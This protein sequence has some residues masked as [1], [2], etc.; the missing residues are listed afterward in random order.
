[1]NAADIRAWLASS[2]D[3]AQGVALYAQAGTS[4]AFK[5][6]F[7]LGATPYSQDVL[8]RELRGLVVEQPALALPAPAPEPVL[9]PTPPPAAED[10][11]PATESPPPASAVVEAL[12]AELA[13]Q[14]KVVRD[15]RSHLHPQLT[16]PGL[17]KTGR[18]KLAG[19]IVGLTDTENE[20]KAA[21]AHVQEHGRL[22]GPVPVAEVTDRGELRR[23]LTNRRAQRSKLKKDLP[24][25]A[26]DL[27]RV[28]ADIDLL[29]QKLA[30]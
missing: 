25:R 9:A 27:A 3:F 5:R 30:F 20:L 21:T 6:L 7:A 18:Q 23:L 22:P 24:A 12:L 28:Q 16:A 2:Q 11:A 17:R 13:G 15:Q 8:L 26:A 14:L 10:P 19:Q 29:T 4:R 1:M